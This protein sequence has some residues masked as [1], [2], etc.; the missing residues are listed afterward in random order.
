MP[1]SML[2]ISPCHALRLPSPPPLPLAFF[3]FMGTGAFFMILPWS[4]LAGATR[5]DGGKV[6]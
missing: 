5:D 3:F 1:L 2:L 4:G 6:D